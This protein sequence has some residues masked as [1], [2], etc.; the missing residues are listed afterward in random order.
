MTKWEPETYRP[1]DPVANALLNIAAELNA[2]AGATHDLLYGLKYG[3][4]QGMSIAEAL[5]VGA[6]KVA[7]AIEDATDRMSA[8]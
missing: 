3:R 7:S 1:G 8:E 5:E 4:E 6:G 2:L